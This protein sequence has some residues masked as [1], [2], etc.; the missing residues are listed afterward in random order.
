MEDN[1]G[2]HPV[3]PREVLPAR[4]LLGDMFLQ[5]N[6]NDNALQAYEAVLTKCANRFNSLYGAAKAAAKKGDEQK[7]IYYYKQLSSITNSANT[8]R[9]ELIDM[10]RFL[11]KY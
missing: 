4:E 2:K 3:I 9:P 11:K 1:T 5:M 10:R 7:A 8:E 6:K